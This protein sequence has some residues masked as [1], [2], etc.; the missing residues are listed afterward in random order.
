M[1]RGRKQYQRERRIS[2]RRMIRNALALEQPIELPELTR[3][4]RQ[5]VIFIE[6]CRVNGPSPALLVRELEASGIAPC[7][8]PGPIRH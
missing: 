2:K 5:S 1:H 8:A 7:R 4:Q 6:L 3:R